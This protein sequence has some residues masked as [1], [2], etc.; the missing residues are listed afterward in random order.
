MTPIARH[1]RT[2]A[3]LRATSVPALAAMVLLLVSAPVSAI[4]LRDIIELSKA[5]VSD[6]ILVEL[7]QTGGSV[8]Y[9]SAIDIVNLKQAGVS[10]RVVVA[11]VRTERALRDRQQAQ[12]DAAEA[13]WVAAQAAEAARAEAEPPPESQVVV[14]LPSEPQIVPVPYPVLL[15]QSSGRGN[16]RLPR[17]RAGQEGAGANRTAEPGARGIIHPMSLP[18]PARQ[19]P[20]AASRP[21]WVVNSSG[22]S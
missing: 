3:W 10:D 5:R 20:G 15:P 22:G 8:F 7:V 11:I 16:S 2:R 18:Q 12:A 21:F 6:D 17:G 9:L 14:Y 4:T 1:S 13:A 19:D